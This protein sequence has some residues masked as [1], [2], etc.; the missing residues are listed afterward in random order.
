MRAEAMPGED[1]SSLATPEDV[2]PKLARL[3]RTE[4]M[5]HAE[6]VNPQTA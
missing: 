4:E 3:C 5:R 2:A 6:I 1:P